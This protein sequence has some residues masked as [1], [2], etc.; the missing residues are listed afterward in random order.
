MKRFTKPLAIGAGFALAAGAIGAT[1]GLGGGAGASDANT[2]WLVTV[3]VTNEAPEQGTL[4]TPVWLGI[5]DGGFDLYDSGVAASPELE[6]LAE[7]GN[8]GP[9]TDLFAASG[10]GMDATT[11]GGPFGPTEQRS[12]TFVLDDEDVADTYFSY[13]SMVIPSNDAFIAN[14][15]P[16]AHPLFDANGDPVAT[17]FSVLGSDVLD[18]GTEVNDE[19]PENTAALAQAAPDTGVDENGVVGAHPGFLPGGNVLDAIPGGDFTQPGYTTASFSFDIRPVDVS[20]RLIFAV[21]DGTEEEPEVDTSSRGYAL[22]RIRRDGKLI[23]VD[24]QFWNT[25]DVVGVHLHY[26]ARGENGPV[27]VNLFNGLSSG[28]AD[29]S[30]SDIRFFEDSFV[31][32]LEGQPFE[33]L[34]E[35]IEDGMIYINVHTQENPSGEIRGQ[36]APTPNL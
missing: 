14:G 24:T 22:F 23:D 32:P 26:G 6:R 2:D 28:L 34:I 1:V 13:A 20:G 18:A 31:G 30:E 12:F 8:T 10:N 9:I 35:A 15:N 25:Y 3:T 4:Q 36:L 19:I 11:P 16:M 33:A 17:D 21:M 29:G 7:D 27:V 5:H